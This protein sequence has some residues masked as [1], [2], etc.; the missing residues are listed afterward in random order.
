M[1]F[2]SAGPPVPETI[3][4]TMVSFLGKER[5]KKRIKLII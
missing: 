5:E 1:S 2:I 3:I 4:N